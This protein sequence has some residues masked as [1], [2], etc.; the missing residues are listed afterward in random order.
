MILPERLRAITCAARSE[1]RK[2]ALQVDAEHVVPPGLV[3]FQEMARC[4]DIARVV[5]QYVD[6]SEACEQR[7]EHGVHLRFIRY[8]GGERQRIGDGAG[9]FA[10]AILVEIVDADQRT[11]SAEALRDG[12]ADAV[13]EAGYENHFAAESSR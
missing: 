12:E 2:G 3:A 4:V 9:G 6:G 5:D 10:G 11:L 8:V 7:V 13:A 1:Q